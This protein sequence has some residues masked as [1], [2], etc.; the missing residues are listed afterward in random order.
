MTQAETKQKK[1]DGRGG[2]RVGAGQ[3]PKTVQDASGEAFVLYS[4]ARAKK[5]TH[6]AKLAELQERQLAKELIEKTQVEYEATRAARLVR[7]AM[8]AIP[9]RVCSLLVGLDEKE[10]NKRL[11][12]E[13]RDSLKGVSD[14]ISV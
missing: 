12:K 10:I 8:L 4:R 3:K 14:E 7:D 2:A 5:E 1:A 11:S 6:N 13:I 9:D